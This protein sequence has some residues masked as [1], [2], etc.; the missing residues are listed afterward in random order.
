MGLLAGGGTAQFVQHLGC[1][2]AVC[3][4]RVPPLPAARIASPEPSKRQS[5][6]SRFAAIG[7]SSVFKVFLAHLISY[8]VQPPSPD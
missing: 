5:A 6:R 4:L 7:A 2:H 8:R 3:R 1:L